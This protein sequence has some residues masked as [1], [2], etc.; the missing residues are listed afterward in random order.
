VRHLIVS[1]VARRLNARPKDISD[2]FYQR[3]LEDTRCPI[4][5]GRRLIPED[6]VPAIEV[7]LRDLGRLPPGPSELCRSADAPAETLLEGVST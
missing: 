6:Y 3:K 5:G 4:V 7:I 1:E 2:L